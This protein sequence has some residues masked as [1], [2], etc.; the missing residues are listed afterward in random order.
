MAFKKKMVV[1]SLSKSAGL[2]IRGKQCMV[3]VL[4]SMHPFV[5]QKSPEGTD[6]IFIWAVSG[7][8]ADIR[9][10]KIAL[11]NFLAE[12]YSTFSKRDLNVQVV[13]DFTTS[14][15]R[16]KFYNNKSMEP[17]IIEFILAEIT[18]NR[19]LFYTIN[20]EGNSELLFQ[21]NSG[22]DAIGCGDSEAKRELI[23]K[24]SELKMKNLSADK[25]IKKTESQLKSYS[26][27]FCGF[28]FIIEDKKIKKRRS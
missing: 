4:K 26:G 15:L 12:F 6:L 8:E 28:S 24:L 18:E 25:I 11:N 21:E 7:S 19:M 17:A 5:F 13:H 14:Y 10:Y 9:N 3:V 2:V 16:Q 23:I 1:D 22:I 27:E 20:H